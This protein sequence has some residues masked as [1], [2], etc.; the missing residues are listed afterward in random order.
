VA[1]STLLQIAMFTVP[2]KLVNALIM[3]GCMPAAIMLATVSGGVHKHT[4]GTVEIATTEEYADAVVLKNQIATL[5][6]PIFITDQFMSLPWFSNDNHAPALAI[7]TIFHNAT[8]AS[9]QNGCIEGMLQRGEI[10]TAILPSKTISESKPVPS[11]L[12]VHSTLFNQTSNVS[13]LHNIFNSFHSVLFIMQHQDL[14]YPGESDDIYRNSL[15]P[16]Y[17]KAGEVRYLD[18]QWSIYVLGSQTSGFDS[19]VTK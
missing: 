4:F 1:G 11:N 9:C 19:Q 17:T 13:F 7:D 2:G 16:K 5:R 12:S 8:R 3:L 10:P 15:S 6:K 18:R 14:F